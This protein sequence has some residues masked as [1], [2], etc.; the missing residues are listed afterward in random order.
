MLKAQEHKRYNRN[1]S[2]G[3]SAW[4]GIQTVA[5]AKLSAF[6]DDLT[7]S[8]L[9]ANKSKWFVS[10][11]LIALRGSLKRKSHVLSA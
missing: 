7:N 6:I 4:A 9:D 11:Q 2:T 10:Y 8:S 3:G 5:K 1:S